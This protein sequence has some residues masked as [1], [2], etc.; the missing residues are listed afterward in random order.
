M[1]PRIS[2]IIP[3]VGRES[4]AAAKASCEGADELIV[5]ENHDG[6]YGYTARHKGMAQA[7]GTHLAFLDDDDVFLPG[8][9]DHFRRWAS[10][11][12]TIFKMDDPI[13]GVLWRDRELRLAN[14]GTP[15]FLVPNV[16]H[17]LGKW[18]PFAHGKCGDFAFISA[19]ADM[20]GGVDWNPEIV[21]RVR[22]HERGPS[23]AVVTP[24][25]DHLEF[26]PDYEQAMEWGRPDEIIVVDNASTPP[27]PLPGVR[28]D[29][30]AGFCEANNI[31]L[32]TAS[33]EAVL[34]LNNDIQAFRTDWLDQI[35][36]QLEPGV[37]VGAKLRFDMHGRV[38]ATPFPY[39]D[40]WCLAGMA[41]DFRELGGWNTGLQEP[42]YFSDNILALEARAAGMSLREVRVGLRHKLNGSTRP[43]D[44]ATVA[45]TNHNRGLFAER[46]RELTALAA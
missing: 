36:R 21:C 44:P 9:F 35:R 3:T 25:K 26:L 34:F 22:P 10:D 11:R 29:Y 42:A 6:D 20:F 8:A 30:N 39:L 45:A 31:G 41:E 17:K 28:L 15:M 43:D 46:V 32:R 37:L 38:G 14:V 5:V 16:P 7:T 4:L 40:G 18:Q 27:V 23:I 13:H 2:V 33:T 12:P 24:W 1:T 19:T